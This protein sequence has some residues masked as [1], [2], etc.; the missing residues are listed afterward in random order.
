MIIC[1]INPDGDSIGAQLLYIIILNQKVKMWH[2]SP[3]NLQEFLKWM[4]GAE[5]IN[6]FIRD[7]KK[8]RTI[9]EKADLIIMVDFNQPNRL[10]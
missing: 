8:C 5:Q 7:R 2:I 1:H 4:D 3:N 9:I 6:I 10:G